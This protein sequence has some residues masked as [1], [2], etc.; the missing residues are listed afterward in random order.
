[1]SVLAVMERNPANPWEVRDQ[2]L[3]EMGGWAKPI[4]WAESKAATINRFFKNK[5]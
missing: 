2:V 4:V 5:V 3:S 1:M